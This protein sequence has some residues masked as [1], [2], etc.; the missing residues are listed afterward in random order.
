MVEL[1]VNGSDSELPGRIDPRSVAFDIDGVIADTMALF[2]DIAREDYGI[3]GISV[4]QITEYSLER[5]LQIEP[6]VITQI[7][8]RIMRGD[9]RQPLKPMDGAAEVLASLADY[10]RPLLFVTA[11]PTSET[12]LAW[13][14]ELLAVA[15]DQVQVI[16]TG[17]FEDKTDVLLGNGIRHFVEDRLE[18]CYQVKAAG[19]EPV[20]YRQPWNRQHH[21]F[22]EVSNWLELKNLIDF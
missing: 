20:V 5:C 1:L 14:E 2:I 17:T 8:M 15:P 7:L 4:E 22:A 9:F 12:I 10:R 21:P 19:I 16:A 11:R 3:N 13:I 6:D 18:T